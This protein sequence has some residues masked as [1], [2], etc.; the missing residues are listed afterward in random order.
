MIVCEGGSGRSETAVLP[1][2]LVPR[3]SSG[4][5][6]GRLSDQSPRLRLDTTTAATTSRS[7]PVGCHRMISLAARLI[8][9]E[10][11]GAGSGLE[12]TDAEESRPEETPS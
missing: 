1:P 8:V 5:D 12:K 3:F 10:L 11:E 6:A 2:E 7:P 4:F 9:E